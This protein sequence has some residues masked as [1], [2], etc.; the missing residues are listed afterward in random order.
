MAMKIEIA[1]S[2]AGHIYEESVFFFLSERQSILPSY[3]YMELV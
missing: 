1:L 2:V 3:N